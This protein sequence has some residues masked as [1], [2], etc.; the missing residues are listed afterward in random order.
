MSILSP[1]RIN[2]KTSIRKTHSM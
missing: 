1:E 2:L